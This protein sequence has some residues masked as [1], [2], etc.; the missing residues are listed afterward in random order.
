MDTK[1]NRITSLEETIVDI[2]LAL[3]SVQGRDL[4]REDPD[5]TDFPL[6]GDGPNVGSGPSS[7]ESEDSREEP[8]PEGQQSLVN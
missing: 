1:R 3:I 5:M 7:D 6:F 2:R 8:E 4:F